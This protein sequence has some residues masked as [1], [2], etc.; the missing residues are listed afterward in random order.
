MYWLGASTVLTR[1]SLQRPAHVW[2]E[3]PRRLL[4]AALLG[5]VCLIPRQSPFL[6]AARWRAAY[7][8]GFIKAA[9]GWHVTEAAIN[10]AVVS[11]AA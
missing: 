7:A 5:P 10:Q 9:F 2:R 8:A 11:V 4:V 1:R 6:L 3:L